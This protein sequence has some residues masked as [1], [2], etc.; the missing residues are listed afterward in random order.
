MSEVLTSIESSICSIV[1]ERP[2][3][4][5]ALN[6]VVIS[7]IRNAIRAAS[8]D[9]AVRIVTIAG[10]GEKIFCA[11]ADLKSA[12]G[13]EPPFLPA[14]YRE[15]LLEILRCP[16]PTIA[17]AKGH[18][19]AGGLGILLAC[20]LAFACNDVHLST[21][22]IHVGMFPM[23]VLALLH[24]HAGRKR[25]TEMVLLGER[26]TAEEAVR[27]GI[28]NR[29]FPRCAFD[30]ETEKVMQS[31]AAKSSALLLQGKEAMLR[32]RDRTMPEELLSLEE[33]L[34]RVMNT[35]DSREGIRAFIEKREPVWK[36]R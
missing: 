11:G 34:I 6:A 14:D 5:N 33:S 26:V 25:T 4:R 16:K 19:M 18:V 17:L 2:K 13:E 21:P 36:D 27:I 24:R 30:E 32:L 8:C 9:P 23:M 15:M 28:L 12:T 7:G 35:E 1:I 10:T 22:E 3:Q 31:L 29:A 20:D